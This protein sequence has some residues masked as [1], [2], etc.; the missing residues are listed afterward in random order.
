MSSYSFL[1][2]KKINVN[3]FTKYFH[4][5]Q[6]P[7]ANYLKISCMKLGFVWFVFDNKLFT[8]TH[9]SHLVPF[10]AAALHFYIVLVYSCLNNCLLICSHLIYIL[11]SFSLKYIFL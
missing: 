6:S 10:H 5:H 7:I 2:F 9:E 3:K 8:Q 4:Y 11:S 1:S